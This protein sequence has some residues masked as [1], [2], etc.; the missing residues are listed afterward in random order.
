MKSVLLPKSAKK[1]SQLGFGCAL[2]SSIR[3]RDAAT[4]LDAAY[5]AGIG[6]FDVAPFYLDGAAEGY[7]GK[8]LSKHDDISSNE[9][10]PVAHLRR[11]VSYPIHARPP[12]ARTSIDAS[13]LEI[14]V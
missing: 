3:E 7:V 2:G 8:F 9:V 5:D 1:T 13:R 4:L 12:Q 11:G 10:W 14:A 6:Y